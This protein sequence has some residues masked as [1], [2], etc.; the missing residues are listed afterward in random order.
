[1]GKRTRSTRTR[2]NREFLAT[3]AA[4]ILKAAGARKVLRIDMAP[5]MLHVQSSMRMGADAGDSV[6]DEWC[7]SR[8]VTGLYIADN[9]ALPNSAGG[10]N[11]TLTAQA[12]AT[13]TSEAIYRDHFGGDAWVGQETPVSSIDQRVT[14]GVMAHGLT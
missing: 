12:L 8:A 9:S 11:P 3:R 13:R 2:A 5:L 7:Q 10:A 4:E 1:M 14:A 6:L